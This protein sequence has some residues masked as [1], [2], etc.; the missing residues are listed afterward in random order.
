MTEFCAEQRR[1]VCPR[2]GI[3][4]LLLDDTGFYYSVKTLRPQKH[5]ETERRKVYISD[6]QNEVLRIRKTLS[7]T[8]RLLYYLVTFFKGFR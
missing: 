3:S 7:A 5:K 2:K 4:I 6:P 1:G 8:Y